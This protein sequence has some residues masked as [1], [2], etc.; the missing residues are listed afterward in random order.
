MRTSKQV[1]LKNF[2]YL[3]YQIYKKRFYHEIPD[4]SEKTQK[5]KKKINHGKTRKDTDGE[6]LENKKNVGAHDIDKQI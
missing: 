1:F 3:S 2:K 4:C 6:A 5:G